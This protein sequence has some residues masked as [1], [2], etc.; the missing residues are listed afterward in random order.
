MLLEH[1]ADAGHMNENGVTALFHAAN[2]GHKEVRQAVR[3]M[4]L[5][6]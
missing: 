6:L 3:P 1:G 5:A 2:Y 4:A